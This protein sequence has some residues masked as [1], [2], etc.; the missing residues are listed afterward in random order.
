MK[1][2][3]TIFGLL[4]AT[5]LFGNFHLLASVSEEKT[6]DGLS[7]TT[8]SAVEG[9]MRRNPPRLTFSPAKVSADSFPAWQ[10]QMKTAMERLMRHPQAQAASPRLIKRVKREG[11]TLEK[12]ESYPLDSTAVPFLV[13]I[14]Y[15]ADA[16]RPLPAALCIPGFGQTKEL[17]AGE[18]ADNFSLEGAPDSLAGKNAMALDY[19]RHGLVAVAVDNPSC[20]ELSDNG[21]FDYLET[22]RFLLECGWSYLGLSSWQD[23][24]ILDWMKTLPYVNKS[25]II[26][27]GFSLGTEPMMAL[28]LLDDSICAFVYNDFLCRTRERALVMNRPDASGVRAFPNSIEHLIPGFLLEFDFPDIVAALAPRPVICTEGGM[29]RDF[30]IVARAFAT[31]GVPDNFSWYHY[32]AFADPANR[33]PLQAMPE[34]IDRATFFRL[35]NVDPPSHHFK[36]ALVL[37]WLDRILM[38]QQQN[39][40]EFK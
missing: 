18:R 1:S 33:V 4:A 11:Y 8:R 24:V 12:W 32:P 37:P 27:S 34:G 7:R 31:A 40:A 21:R 14:P 23:R 30:E 2:P 5:L 19:V 10:A 28:G 22:S 29:D 36:S 9:L 38:G 16:A 35:A 39:N 15:G 17:L 13:L 26:A 25:R 6:Q 20:G 3:L